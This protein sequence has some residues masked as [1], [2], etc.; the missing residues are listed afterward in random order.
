VNVPVES[1]GTFTQ[2]PVAIPHFG[3]SDR[4]FLFLCVG[5]F[6][7]ASLPLRVQ[8]H[9]VGWRE[10][11]EAERDS[12]RMDIHRTIAELSDS[13]RP[14]AMALVLRAEGSTPCKAGARA[15]IEETG[16]IWGTVGGG[17]VEAEAQRQAI[18]ACNTKRPVVFDFHLEG[19]DTGDAEPICGGIMRILVDPTAAQDR[20][21][22]AQ[23][24]EA[25]ARRTRGVLLT[26]VRTPTE[27]GTTY[28]AFGAPPSGGKPTEVGTTYAEVTVQWFAEGVVSPDV[29]FPNAEA[30]RLCLARE[31]PQW[32]VNESHE[33]GEREEAFVEPVIPKPNLLIVGGGHVG[34]ALARQAVLTGFD[35]TVVDDRPEFTNA[36]LFPKGVTT[37][38]GD[39]AEEVADFP[40]AADTYIVIV[41]RGHQHDAEALH[42]CIHA[43]AAYIG[44]IGSRRKVA[45]LRKTFVESGWATEE[46]FDRV[47]A[48][49][50]LDIGSVTVPEIATSIVAQLIAVRR[51]GDA[52]KMSS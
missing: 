19:A 45:L 41:T 8:G 9:M 11:N 3:L 12:Q 37:R 24:A 26:S 35:V 43:S 7:L 32:L 51:K 38:C 23:A 50:G 28:A 16:K 30:V 10:R 1:R 22:Y 21:A 17:K 42:A 25:I 46:E 40:T 44:M 27:V 29:G 20:S 52:P 34:Q 6:L 47:F 18:E 48:P 15:A 5:V 33:A 49:I 14:F 36:A 4:E 2:Y 13:G 31:T 39:I